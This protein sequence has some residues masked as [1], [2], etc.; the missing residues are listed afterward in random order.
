MKYNEL[1]IEL[2]GNIEALAILC[3]LSNCENPSVREISL[4][5]GISKSKVYRILAKINKKDKEENFG[6]KISVF[7][8]F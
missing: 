3:V 8:D 4:Y 7:C 1:M 5:T 6:I 2:K